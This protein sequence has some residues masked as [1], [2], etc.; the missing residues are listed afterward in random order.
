M[1]MACVTPKLRLVEFEIEGPGSIIAVGNANPMST[2]SYQQPQRTSWQGRCLV[3]VKAGKEAGNIV[4][5][6]RAAGLQPAEI[7]LSSQGN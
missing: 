7:R 2:E 6:A 1:P 5:R 3:I 4:L